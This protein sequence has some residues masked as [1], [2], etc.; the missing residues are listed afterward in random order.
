M[1]VS[2]IAVSIDCSNAEALAGF[3]AGLLERDVDAGATREFASIGLAGAGSG[4]AAWMF[5]SV[6][7]AGVPKRIKNR[8]H[9][10]LGSENLDKAVAHAIDLGAQRLGDFEEGGFKWTSL[11]DPEGNEF[12]IVAA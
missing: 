7:E 6:P 1:S 3:W 10:D 12:D 8:L 11:A 4:S 2:L 5:H 9:V